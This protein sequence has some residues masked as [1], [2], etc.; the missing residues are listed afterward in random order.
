MLIA[1]VVALLQQASSNS[2]WVAITDFQTDAWCTTAHDT[3]SGA[4][5]TECEGPGVA[6]PDTPADAIC[7]NRERFV[8]RET[9]QVRVSAIEVVECS[10]PNWSIRQSRTDIGEDAIAESCLLREWLRAYTVPPSCEWEYVFIAKLQD[11][12]NHNFHLVECS[13]GQLNRALEY[14]SAMA[15]GAGPTPVD[16]QVAPTQPIPVVDLERI[17]AG[18]TLMSVISD[19]GPPNSVRPRHPD[20]ISLVYPLAGQSGQA[21]IH[22]DKDRRAVAAL[23]CVMARINLNGLGV[24]SNNSMNLTSRGVAGRADARPAGGSTRRLC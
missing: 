2:D 10:D 1:I 22:F 3:V 19:Y 18:A 21:V 20:A 4:R 11:G 15:T 6:E 13:S 9:R 7:G 23:H 5:V 12:R 16:E 14:V 8:S 17:G 24:R